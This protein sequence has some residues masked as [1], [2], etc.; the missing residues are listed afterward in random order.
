[1]VKMGSSFKNGMFDE[2]ISEGLANWAETARRRKRVP[3]VT[4]EEGAGIQ[5]TNNSRR[6]SA[7]EQGSARLI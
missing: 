7:M 1:M 4:S 5:M 3:V 6:D 2:N